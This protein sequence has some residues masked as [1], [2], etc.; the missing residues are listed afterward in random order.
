MANICALTE[1]YD[2]KLVPHGNH[3]LAATHVVAAHPE[4]LCP[5]V[6]YLMHGYLDR[7]QYYQK[8]PLQA[9]QG[10]L[11]L[12]TVPGLGLEIDEAKVVTRKELQWG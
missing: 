6:E 2:V 5:M 3:V 10:R 9:E 4:S 8:T 11:K 1:A 7:M 12:P